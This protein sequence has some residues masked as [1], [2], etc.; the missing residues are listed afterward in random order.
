[1]YK[2]LTSGLT[3]ATRYSSI[4]AHGGGSSHSAT[5]TAQYDLV[6][7]RKRSEDGGKVGEK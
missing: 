3:A 1:M 4:I 2:H 6:K 7:P 5:I